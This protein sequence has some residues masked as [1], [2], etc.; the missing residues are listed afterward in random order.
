MAMLRG[1]RAMR[2]IRRPED[3][4]R[5]RHASEGDTRHYYEDLGFVTSEAQAEAIRADQAGFEE[6]Y[7][8]RMEDVAEMREKLGKI[9][10]AQKAMDDAWG[11]A[12]SGFVQVNLRGA[13][14]PSQVE[15]TGDWDEETGEGTKREFEV[16][17]GD[18]IQSY[19]LPKDVAVQFLE[20]TGKKGVM[21]DG[22]AGE[23][24][25]VSHYWGERGSDTPFG[26]SN[27]L[28]ISHTGHTKQMQLRDPLAQIEGTV[29]TKFYEQ[30]MP[31]I[32]EQLGVM[33][34][35]ES[36]IS[37]AEGEATAAKKLRDKQF[38]DARKDYLKRIEN[39]QAIFGKLKVS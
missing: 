28:N 4:E 27:V 14:K 17:E 22:E 12:K 25:R 8:T 11:K 20:Q 39:M 31:K 19:W 1:Q 24:Y 32:A 30:A 18:V 29:K 23:E 35:Y 26:E 15:G 16:G 34:G 21:K 33:R 3:V 9:P 38:A 7:G 36:Q 2:D 6:A 13:P 10:S 37:V 5:A